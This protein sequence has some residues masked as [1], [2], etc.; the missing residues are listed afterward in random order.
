MKK[1]W[2]TACAVWCVLL[3]AAQAQT[4][5]AALFVQNRAGDQLEGKIDAFSEDM[6]AHLAD[7]G[8]QVIMPRD[9]LAR[10]S[11]SREAAAAQELRQA[12]EALQLLKTE[13]TAEDNPMDAASALRVAESLDADYLVMA[14]LISLGENVVRTQAYGLPQ[15]S[16]T[17]VLR[18]GLRVLDGRTGAQLYADR[19]A[20]TDKIIQTAFQETTAGDQ[21]DM[22]LDEGAGELA[23][24]VQT[25]TRGTLATP[26]APEAPA[27]VTVQTSVPD[28][29]VE[30]D[31]L[32]VGTTPGPFQIRPGIHRMRLT[33]EGY[34]TWEK[35]VKVTDGQVLNIAM[36]YSGTGLDRRGELLQQ[37]RDDAVVREQS[38]AKAALLHGQ[39]QAASNSFSRTENDIHVNVEGTPNTLGIGSTIAP[40]PVQPVIVEP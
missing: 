10:F 9:V 20:V 37:D 16:Q 28:V 39:A 8:F 14:T 22:L 19:T 35:S 33:K 18:L 38:E 1:Y 11:E 23:A 7:A 15:S 30:V 31:G 12:A 27:S 21:V 29:T 36:E 32:A 6:A 3:G 5:T 26:P 4:P 17:T 2:M 34:A 24:R 13:G 25:A 40:Y